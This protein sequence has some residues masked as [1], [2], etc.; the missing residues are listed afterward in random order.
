[1]VK[2]DKLTLELIV[3]S[4]VSNNTP[5]IITRQTLIDSLFHIYKGGKDNLFDLKRDIYKKDGARHYR[6]S[7]EEKIYQGGILIIDE[8]LINEEEISHYLIRVIS[9][10]YKEQQWILKVNLHLIKYKETLPSLNKQ[11]NKELNLEALR[12]GLIKVLKDT[13]YIQQLRIELETHPL[14]NIPPWYYQLE[15]IKERYG[16]KLGIDSSERNPRLS[17]N[18]TLSISKVNLVNPYLYSNS[19]V[20]DPK[21]F[22]NKA[23]KFD[24]LIDLLLTVA[25]YLSIKQLTGIYNSIEIYEE[26]EWFEDYQCTKHYWQISIALLMEQLTK[27]KKRKRKHDKISHTAKCHY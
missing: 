8:E 3:G 24:S 25:P 20:I 10:L 16:F 21:A 23:E 6:L 14:L 15:D 11:K 13:P 2:E 5:I 22:S 12:E 26:V 4:R 18:T 1:M 17:K 19:W 9:H 7:E 27:Y